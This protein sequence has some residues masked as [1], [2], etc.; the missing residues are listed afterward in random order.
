MTDDSELNRLAAHVLIDAVSA[1]NFEP[2]A[3]GDS[4]SGAINVAW[5]R[6]DEV[7]AM[8]LRQDG[9]VVTVDASPLL[10]GVLITLHALILSVV[11]AT[12]RDHADVIT[13]LR[14][15]VDEAIDY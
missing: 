10:N 5:E 9:N 7:K 2:Y 3:A 4:P 13:A 15:Q 11:A 12:G 6:L 14:E 8:R 1:W